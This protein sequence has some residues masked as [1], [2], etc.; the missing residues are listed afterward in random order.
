[1]IGTKTTIKQDLAQMAASLEQEAADNLSQAEQADKR[2]A[3][4][5]ENAEFL[6][7]KAEDY[8]K[9]AATLTDQ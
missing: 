2:A 3:G 1:M 5:R 9:L 8:R 7:A 4:Y 6:K